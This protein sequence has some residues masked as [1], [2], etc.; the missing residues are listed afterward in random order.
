LVGEVWAEMA[1]R[2]P[3]GQLDDE[4]LE[5]LAELLRAMVEPPAR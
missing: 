5:Q 2:T 3:V 4:Q 1:D